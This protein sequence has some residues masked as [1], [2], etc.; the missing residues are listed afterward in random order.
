MKKEGNLEEL[1]NSLDKIVEEAKDWKE[2]AW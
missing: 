2:P 1:F